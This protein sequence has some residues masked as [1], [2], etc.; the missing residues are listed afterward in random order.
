MIQKKIK[1]SDTKNDTKNY[2]KNDTNN[3]FLPFLTTQKCALSFHEKPLIQIGK[4]EYGYGTYFLLQFW[5]PVGHPLWVRPLVR[6]CN[7]VLPTFPSL[8][9]P[10][11]LTRASLYG[12]MLSGWRV[13]I[14]QNV[15]VEWK[16]EKIKW[17][18]SNFIGS[19]IC[20]PWLPQPWLYNYAL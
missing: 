1:K 19:W 13:Y 15:P 10:F 12:A 20:L 14:L 16:R 11:L 2:T 3:I 17:T 9:L 7:G 5:R 6:A 4:L 18:F 8:C